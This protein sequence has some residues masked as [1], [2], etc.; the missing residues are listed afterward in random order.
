MTK[1]EIETLIEEGR[2]LKARLVEARRTVAEKLDQIDGLI[3]SLP[4]GGTEEPMRNAPK[5]TL[6]ELVMRTVRL[7]HRPL[8][9][10]EITGIISALRP[11]APYVISSTLSRLKKSGSLHV[12]GNRGSY[13]FTAPH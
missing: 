10:R 6:D 5:E 8:S 13:Q 1:D 2:K 11:T 7:S 4:N 3:R 9:S 12:S